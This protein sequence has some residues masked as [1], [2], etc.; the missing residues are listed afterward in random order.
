MERLVFADVTSKNGSALLNFTKWVY[1]SKVISKTPAKYKN[2]NV[3][4]SD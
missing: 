3:F 1:K 2:K 4:Q